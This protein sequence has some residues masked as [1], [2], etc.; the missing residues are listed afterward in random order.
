[1][2]ES[3]L[4]LPWGKA[5]TSQSCSLR[6]CSVSLFLLKGSTSVTDDFLRLM[7]GRGRKPDKVCKKPA[8]AKGAKK[9]A[10]TVPSKPEFST[11]SLKV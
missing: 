6:C 11:Q 8:A 2:G 1:M 9:G 10:K 7:N 4:P 3:S 5:A